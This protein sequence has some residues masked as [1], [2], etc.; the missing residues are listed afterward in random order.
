MVFTMQYLDASAKKCNMQCMSWHANGTHWHHAM[1]CL[2][3]DSLHYMCGTLLPLPEV[4]CLAKKCPLL[5]V[6]HV[7]FVHVGNLVFE[8]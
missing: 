3:T 2:A 4:M 6:V 7:M 1:G 5:P 8:L